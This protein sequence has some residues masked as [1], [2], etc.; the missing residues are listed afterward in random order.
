MSL[1][2]TLCKQR[3]EAKVVLRSQHRMCGPIMEL[4]NEITYNSTLRAASAEVAEARLSLP[5]LS[6]VCFL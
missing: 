1:F 3:P 5:Q 6:N 4:N 2:E